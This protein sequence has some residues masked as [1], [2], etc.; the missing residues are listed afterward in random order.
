MV[1]LTQIVAEILDQFFTLKAM[2]RRESLP[3]VLERAKEIQMQLKDWFSNLPPSL[4]VDETK[5][6]RLSSVGYLH[7]A[8]YT[9]EITLHRAILRSHSLPNPNT[10]LALITRRAACTRF[11]SALD[12]V[13]RLKQEHLQ[14]FWYFSSSISL[15]I[16]GIFATVLAVTAVEP[17]ERESYIALLAEYRW[18]LRISNTGADFM[19]YAVGLL[20]SKSQLLEEQM[21]A[22]ASA[23]L[24]QQ[25][26]AR[27]IAEENISP[28]FGDSAYLTS[29]EAGSWIER[30]A[31]TPQHLDFVQGFDDLNTYD[32]EGFFGFD[33]VGQ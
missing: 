2:R 19:K 4:S 22:S 29:P 26:E 6:R 33:S 27:E 5:P 31:F 16:V 32:M 8:Y 1:S 7:L 18:I 12:F 25:T 14:S 9:A 24:R 11:T 13:K 15:A 28:S 30:T 3:D 20:D 23:A 17:E 21:D 10:D